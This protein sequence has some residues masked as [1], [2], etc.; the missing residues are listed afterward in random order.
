MLT[1]VEA[2]LRCIRAWSH[3][4]KASL[5]SSPRVALHVN[6]SGQ[7]GNCVSVKHTPPPPSPSI[8]P[9]PTPGLQRRAR[10]AAQRLSIPSRANVPSSVG[11]ARS[12]TPSLC[13]PGWLSGPLRQNLG[14]GALFYTYALHWEDVENATR[15]FTGSININ[16]ANL[17]S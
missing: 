2:P 13:V 4:L 7:A 1:R 11:C 17:F 6:T 9:T 8:A 12:N 10:A 3:P 15:C 14:L 16:E 5:P